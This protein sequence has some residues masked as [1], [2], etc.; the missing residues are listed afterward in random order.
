MVPPVIL[1]RPCCR[2]A[3]Q[4]GTPPSLK[5]NGLA[6]TEVPFRAFQSRLARTFWPLKVEFVERSIDRSIFDRN[7]N[8]VRGISRTTLPFNRDCEPQN[9]TWSDQNPLNSPESHIEL[10]I[11]NMTSNKA[12]DPPNTVTGRAFWP[13][14]SFIISL[15]W[16]IRESRASTR[17]LAIARFQ[18]VAVA[19][20]R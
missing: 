4:G 18:F 7:I 16:L 6:E 1:F 11:D 17:V 20:N 10:P 2:L 14:S 13:A 19:M 15:A 3:L 9:L 8:F 5:F 12:R